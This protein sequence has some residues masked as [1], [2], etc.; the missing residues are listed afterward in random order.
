[1]KLIRTLLDRLSDS[2][3]VSVS[4]K[5]EL[6]IE[7][8]NVPP[9]RLVSDKSVLSTSV[10][11]ATRRPASHSISQVDTLDDAVRRSQAWFLSRQ[12]VSEGYWVAELEADTTLTSEYLMLRRFLDRVDPERERKAVY[13][14]RAVQL[15]DG[16]WPIFYGGP[17]E[18][19]ASVKAYFALKLSGIS[20]DEPYMLRARDRI[21]AMGGVVCA[22]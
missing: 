22:N 7:P 3:F 19:S 20:A 15:P 21:L 9:L 1:M 8:S 4:E 6:A 10:D 12:H 11:A 18:I 5:L 16:G 2:F 17:S 13:Y 14:L